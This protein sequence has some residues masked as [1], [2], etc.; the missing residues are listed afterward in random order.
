M[1]VSVVYFILFFLLFLVLLLLLVFNRP[2]YRLR[3]SQQPRVSILIAARNEEHI[4]L[5]CLQAIEALDYPKDK[6]EVLVGN[7]ASTD[8]TQAV[9]EAFIQGKPSYRCV[10]ITH[11]VGKAKGKANVLAQLA[12]YATSNYFFYTDADIAV[13]PHW[14]EGMLSEMRPEVGVV[15]GITTITGNSLF[16]R[17]QAMD[18][19]Y[20]LG[21]MQV[22]SDLKLPVTAMGNNMVLRREAY[23][24]VGGFEK[25]EFSVTEDIAIFNQVLKRGW[26]FR[27]M[28]SQEVLALSTP[29]TSFKQY[30]HQRKRWMRG[31]MHL[32]LYMVII[33]ILHSA[34]YPVL[35]PFFAY[36]S[37]GVATAVFTFKLLLQSLYVYVCLRR[38]G[39]TAPWWLYIL[40]EVYLVVTSVMLIIF[41]FLPFKTSWKGR[42][43]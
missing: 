26:G 36:T 22:V 23:E 35:L 43:Y 25:I 21:L 40:F 34:Y 16:A 17:L 18:W 39:R 14:I 9:V 31:S 15:T 3:L 2:K 42:Q 38:L 10:S 33:F 13:P 28:Y 24:E 19:L 1:I 20:A 4:I 29:A 32:P 11:N 27:N 5:R 12:H 8:N 37:L 30:L 41:F 7:D 6:I